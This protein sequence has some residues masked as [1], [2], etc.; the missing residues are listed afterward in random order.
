MLLAFYLLV[1]VVDDYF[2]NSLDKIA[3]DLRMSSDAA[4]S[5]TS[6]LFVALFA[7][8]RPRDHA[9]IGI[10]NIVGSALFNILSII[11]AVAVV[12]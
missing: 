2:V 12:K 3:S 5:N 9:V 4:G 6:E 7:V 1:K 8:F 11:C 10:G